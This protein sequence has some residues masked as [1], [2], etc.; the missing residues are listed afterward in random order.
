MASRVQS[1]EDIR[2]GAF[3]QNYAGFINELLDA[4]NIP[5]VNLNQVM[6]D[7][8]TLPSVNLRT[9]LT[10][11]LQTYLESGNL[12]IAPREQIQQ[13]LQADTQIKL[14]A[15]NRDTPLGKILEENVEVKRLWQEFSANLGKMQGLTILRKISDPELPKTLMKML[16]DKINNVND[17]LA[18]N[19]AQAGGGTKKNEYRLKYVKYNL[20]NRTLQLQIDM[21]KF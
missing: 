8:V 6:I 13:L 15:E 20:K 2:R 9:K 21:Q 16:N 19:L 17:I 14:Q 4:L 5:D 7:G 11:E 18:S 1:T 3:R 12:E 10:E